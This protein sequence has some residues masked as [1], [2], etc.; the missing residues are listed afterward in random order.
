MR[1]THPPPPRWSMLVSRQEGKFS[2]NS[3]LFWG[4]HCN[5][6]KQYDFTTSVF[7]LLLFYYY[8][9]DL[10]QRQDVEACE[11]RLGKANRIVKRQAK[12]SSL[13]SNRFQPILEA[14]P[15]AYPKRRITL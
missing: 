8:D 12:F 13:S 4:H 6:F 7:L 15:F 14:T 2:D 10:Y 9:F 1:L 5:D 11:S 3:S